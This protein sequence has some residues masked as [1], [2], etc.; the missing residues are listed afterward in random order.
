MNK[1]HPTYDVI[2]VKMTSFDYTV[3]ES[4]HRFVHRVAKS[5]DFEIEDSWAHP[6]KKTK[7]VRYKPNSTNLETEYNLTAYERYIQL[8]D[9]QSPIYSVFLRFI[10]TAIP[11]GV[12]LS[13]VHHTDFTEESRY[14]PDKEL[15]DLKA[16]LEAAGGAL[17]SRK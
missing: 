9:V 17:K 16:Q 2:N 14:V 10:Q 12:K 5:L 4:Y 7:I 3:L 15:I 6:P 11:E 8:E 13:V 1:P